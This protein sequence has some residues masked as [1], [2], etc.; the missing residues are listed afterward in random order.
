MAKRQLDFGSLLNGILSGS[1][2]RGGSG[3]NID[4]IKIYHSNSNNKHMIGNTVL[5]NSHNS[6]N[7][8]NSIGSNN[9]SNLG[10]N[11]G[12]KIAIDSG[13]RMADEELEEEDEEKEEEE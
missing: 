10:N 8:G 2:G 12:N 1:D 5:A 4:N 3:A 13:D 11:T 6:I 7:N 9:N